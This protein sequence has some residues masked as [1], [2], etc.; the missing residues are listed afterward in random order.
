MRTPFSHYF[1]S[2]SKAP[3]LPS[4]R[5]ALRRL[6]ISQEELEAGVAREVEEAISE[7]RAE[8]GIERFTAN[9]SPEAPRILTKEDCLALFHATG[10]PPLGALGGVYCWAAD[11][12]SSRFNF[13][14]ENEDY[15]VLDAYDCSLPPSY[16]AT[17]SQE[18]NRRAL[19][20]SLARSAAQAAHSEAT[21]SS[22]GG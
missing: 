14:I 6:G 13:K 17:R 8:R 19:A 10:V 21:S 15:S 3:R 18:A 22:P 20:D 12:G 16:D 2:A 7:G 5:F 11:L 1:A 9:A 4:N